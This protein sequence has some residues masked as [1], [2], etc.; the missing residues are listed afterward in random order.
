ME[1]KRFIDKD[2]LETWV[3]KM[4]NYQEMNSVKVPTVFEVI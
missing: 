3:I 2:Q 1:T 4:A